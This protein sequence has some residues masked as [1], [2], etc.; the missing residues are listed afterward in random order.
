MGTQR[1]T[2]SLLHEGARKRE[3]HV[4]MKEIEEDTNSWKD[5]PCSWIGRTDIVKM[6]ILPKVI[7]RVNVIPNKLPMAFFTELEPKKS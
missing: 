7:Y 2:R 6:T 4:L 3:C 1:R 5:I